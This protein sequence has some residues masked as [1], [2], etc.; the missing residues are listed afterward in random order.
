[1]ARFLFIIWDGCGSLPPLIGVAQ[2]PRARGHA[3]PFVVQE[4]GEGLAPLSKPDSF[5]YEM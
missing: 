5:S 4:L 1:M 2:G 3:V